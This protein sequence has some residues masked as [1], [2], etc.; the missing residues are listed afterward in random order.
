[1]RE[2]F[3][4][5]GT[6]SL[7]FE[8]ISTLGRLSAF[9]IKMLFMPAHMEAQDK[10]DIIGECFQR[11]INLLKQFISVAANGLTPALTMPIKPKFT[12]YLPKD[13]A[14]EIANLI[15]AKTGGIL[16][17]DTAVKLNPLVAD[18]DSELE[19]IKKDNEVTAMIIGE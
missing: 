5:T 16:S 11:R 4:L 3:I 7:D 19:Q 10:E 15:T 13:D 8:A 1:M 17:T 14:E 9:T 18:A 12:L 6:P 2:V